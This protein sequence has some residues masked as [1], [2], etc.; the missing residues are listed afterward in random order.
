M[1]CGVVSVDEAYAATGSHG[2]TVFGGCTGSSKDLFD[3]P[4][5]AFKK[6]PRSKVM[7]W[8]GA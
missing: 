2:S 1:I 6:Y 4:D 7:Q 8:D 3:S 5:D